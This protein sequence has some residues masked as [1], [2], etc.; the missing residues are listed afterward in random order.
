M[1]VERW[2]SGRGSRR[3][4]EELLDGEAA[5]NHILT[6]DAIDRGL[7][8]APVLLD[9]EGTGGRTTDGF[10]ALSQ[11]LENFIRGRRIHGASYHHHVVDLNRSAGAL[12]PS[13]GRSVDVLDQ[14][15][16]A[17]ILR[18]LADDRRVEVA[19]EQHVRHVL[20][21]RRALHVRRV[22]ELRDMRVFEGYPADST[23]IDSVVV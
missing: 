9:T 13:G 11:Q 5:W 19:G 21:R 14:R 8:V 7:E 22:T 4:L 10:P 3:S 6:V 20:A 12:A 23:Q 16:D 15:L 2:C 17:S 18:Q 1:P